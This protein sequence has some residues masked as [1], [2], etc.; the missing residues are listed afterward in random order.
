MVLNIVVSLCDWVNVIE[1][2]RES[3]KVFVRDVI[4]PHLKRFEDCG[5][6]I[7]TLPSTLTREQR[8]KIHRLTSWDFKG[9]SYDIDGGWRIM[10]LHIHKHYVESLFKDYVFEKEVQVV[11][12]KTDKQKLFELILAFLE[13]NL[14]DEFDAYISTI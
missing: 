14:E 1:I 13:E 9:K 3:F 10:Q 2:E 11:V 8:H 12:P 7:I 6:T 5:T 4:A